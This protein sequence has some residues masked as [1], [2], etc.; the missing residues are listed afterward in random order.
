VNI[1]ENYM[2]FSGTVISA[3]RYCLGRMTYMPSLVIEF[4]TPY[5][6]E[7]ET[8]DLYVIQRDIVEHGKFVVTPQKVTLTYDERGLCKECYGDECDY[9]TWMDFLEKVEAEL[10]NRKEDTEDES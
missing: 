9:R 8:K 5:L 3:L 2:G 4:V 6:Q 7:M 10:Y 1:K